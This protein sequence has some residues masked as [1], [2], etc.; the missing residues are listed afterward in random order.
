MSDENYSNTLYGWSLQNSYGHTFVGSGG[1]NIANTQ[2]NYLGYDA[3]IELKRK[4]GLFIND[5]GFSESNIHFE[6]LTNKLFGKDDG[7]D[8]LTYIGEM[9]GDNVN[10][11]VPVPLKYWAFDPYDNNIIVA[12]EDSSNLK[13]VKITQNGDTPTNVDDPLRF[14]SDTTTITISSQ[15]D[16]INAYNIG[17]VA[18]KY[19]FIKNPIFD[20]YTT[21]YLSISDNRTVLSRNTSLAID[22]PSNHYLAFGTNVPLKSST[23]S[24]NSIES[25]IPTLQE[26]GF[27]RFRI[28][29]SGTI[30]G[31]AD[32]EFYVG[33]C[34][35]PA[36][37]WLNNDMSAGTGDVGV[38]TYTGTEFR[39][40]QIRSLGTKSCTLMEVQ[41]WVG[42]DN[43]AAVANGAAEAVW[44]NYQDPDATQDS[45]SHQYNSDYYYA[46]LANNN[47]LGRKFSGPCFPRIATLPV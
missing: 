25:G 11:G 1:V 36:K 35:Q 18:E 44:I 27:V 23:V 45:M 40:L 22:P 47:I 43:I 21:K 8:N 26:G 12:A 16:L 33:I 5:G 46:S 3:H 20:L 14:V 24:I 4:V 34:N 28:D 10:S 13:M 6:T 37:N 15:S 41:A 38:A 31:D 32:L 29:E 7:N 17:T 2:Y 9:G 19:T 30:D 42:N 39:Y